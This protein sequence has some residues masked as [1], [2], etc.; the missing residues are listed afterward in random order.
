MPLPKM[1][2][3]VSALTMYMVSRSPLGFRIQTAQHPQ[4]PFQAIPFLVSAAG[5]VWGASEISEV[6]PSDLKGE[7]VF[8]VDVDLT[9]C[10]GRFSMM[11]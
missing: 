6:K 1:N 4:H 11:T 10:S 9:G 2:M 3:M 7:G 8:I 5:F